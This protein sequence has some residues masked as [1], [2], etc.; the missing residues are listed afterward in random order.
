MYLNWELQDYVKCYFNMY[1]K[2]QSIQNIMYV[3]L[4]MFDF[5]LILYTWNYAKISSDENQ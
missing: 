5:I 3:L 2:C 1:V 4:V